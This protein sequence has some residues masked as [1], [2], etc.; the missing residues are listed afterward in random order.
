MI[1]SMTDHSSVDFV[2]PLANAVRHYL[3][4]KPNQ[5]ISEDDHLRQVCRFLA[6]FLDRLLKSENGWGR[7][8]S[9]DDVVPCAA[10]RMSQHDL[11]VDGLVIWMGDGRGE[12]IDP[13]SASIYVPDREDETMEYTLLFG[14]AALGLGKI[15]YGA[16]QNF[17]YVTVTDWMFVFESKDRL[18]PV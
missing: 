11:E 14:N 8:R 7:Y 2:T 12:W 18:K 6:P 16:S 10:K 9:V 17:P 3:Q 5:R 4:Q 15:A 1:A 13:V